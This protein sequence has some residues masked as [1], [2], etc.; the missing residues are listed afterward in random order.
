MIKFIA[1]QIIMYVV[2]SGTKDAV[3]TWEQS[4]IFTGIEA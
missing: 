4:G 3:I 2:A 1:S